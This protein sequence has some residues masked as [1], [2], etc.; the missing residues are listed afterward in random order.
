MASWQEKACVGGLIAGVIVALGFLINWIVI[1]TR[2]SY[3][4]VSLL[5]A[6]GLDVDEED[7]SS[8]KTPVEFDVAIGL[9]HLHS[10]FGGVGHDGGH[11]TIS[12]AG[13]ELADGP[14]SKFYVAA[15]AGDDWVE[16][17]RAVVS[18][19]KDQAPPSQL[20]RDHLW[21]D[22]QAHGE[23]AF[24]IALTLFNVNI[25][26]GKTT[27]SYHRC[28]AGLARQGRKAKPSKCGQPSYFIN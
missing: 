12:Y 27:Y 20:F 11:M 23:A 17:T 22:Q 8:N 26:T 9:L 6:R 10:S 1:M 19:G 3:I 24:D 16:A 28:K 5:D 4:T 25:T 18:A 15:G 14:V 2:H 7:T 13:I 21:V